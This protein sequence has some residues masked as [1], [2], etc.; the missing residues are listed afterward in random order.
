MTE[1]TLFPEDFFEQQLR[2]LPLRRQKSSLDEAREFGGWTVDKLEILRL[3]FTVYRK[4]AGNGTYIDG[5]AGTGE[6][7]S[8][9]VRYPGSAAIA[10]RS[11]A[12]RT[13]N[14]YERPAVAKQLQQWV[15]ANASKTQ[16][17]RVRII[18]G[19]FNKRVLAD[20][21][22]ASL[23][24]D[25]P[26]FAFLDPNSTQLNWTTVEALARYKADCHPPETC[27]IELWLLFNT[28]QV[29]MRLMP[30]SGKEPNAK[31]LNRW[32][33]GE[34]GWRDLYQQRRGAGAFAQRYAERLMSEFGYGLARSLAIRDPT[35]GKRQYFMI[36]ASD[37]PAAHEF[38][39][40]AA[41]KA[42]PD[43]SEAVELPG[44]T[45]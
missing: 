31:I 26:C 2:K 35:T 10:L 34:A 17:P 38:M 30:K 25:R 45:G 32:C 40:W 23:S 18:G 14:F 5:F 36:H 33:G 41:K 20:L 19:D 43:G 4:V 22:I 15:D 29:L 1:A 7:Q 8:G 42:H 11:G 9:G 12:F 6:I 13:W 44:F 16:R 24:K 37:H 3:Y 21:A 28:D 27:R 39:R